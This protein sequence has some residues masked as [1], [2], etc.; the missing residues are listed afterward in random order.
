M[1]KR[2]RFRIWFQPG[3]AMGRGPELGFGEPGVRA[4]WT[5]VRATAVEGEGLGLAWRRM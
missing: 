5:A 1:G 4:R 3:P 2:L